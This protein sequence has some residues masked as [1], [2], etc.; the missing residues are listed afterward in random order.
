[1]MAYHQ[2]ILA[3]K[4]FKCGSRWQSCCTVV[5]SAYTSGWQMNQTSWQPSRSKMDLHDSSSWVKINC[6]QTD[7][8]VIQVRRRERFG[9]KHS[10]FGIHE[11]SSSHSQSEVK[12]SFRIWIVWSTGGMTS[13]TKLIFESG[14]NGARKQKN[15]TKWEFRELYFLRRSLSERLH[16]MYLRRQ[17][18]CLWRV[19]VPKTNVYKWHRR[20]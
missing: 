4:L 13:R 1:M 2:R 20:M 3:R 10:Q 8:W 16:F 6:Q 11:D 14:V 17:P 15:L 7:L 12:S 9:A 19:C 18:G 5:V